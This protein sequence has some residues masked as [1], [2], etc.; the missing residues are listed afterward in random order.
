MA[1]ADGT[2]GSPGRSCRSVRP[3]CA[4]DPSRARGTARASPRMPPRDVLATL[5]RSGPAG[6]GLAAAVL[7]AIVALAAGFLD[8]L[9]LLITVG[10][11]LGVTRVTFSRARLE[12][13]WRHV[14][15]AVEEEGSPADV[16]ATLKRLAR[17][18]RTE[19]EPALERAA[20]AER[21]PLVRRGIA[22]ALECRDE[23]E[24]VD[25]LSAEAR[26]TA[27]EGEAAR[28]VLLTLG[29]LFPAFGLIG[30]LIGLVLLMHHLGDGSFT[31]I[32]PGLGVAVL[33][34]LYGAVFANI[35]V[36]PLATKL[37]AHL[38]REALRT[39]MILD[40][41]VLVRQQEYPTRIERMLLGYVGAPAVERRRP[42]FGV[43]GRAA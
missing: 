4:R 33:T 20:A 12:S 16:V 18:Y 24:L 7:I 26:R 8:P 25:L 27:A 21:D 35:V 39:Q 6:V 29:K 22:L 36:L 13:T 40:G 3:S 14:V 19:G 5:G 2:N 28:H 17:I 37:H 10:G 34:T 31:T 41:V 23:E 42:T 11:V 9:S 32:G 38:A 15:A 1:A 30:T 43:A